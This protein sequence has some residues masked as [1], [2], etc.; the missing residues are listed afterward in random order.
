MLQTVIH[1]DASCMQLPGIQHTA[2]EDGKWY[3]ALPVEADIWHRMGICR[4]GRHIRSRSTVEQW[5][6]CWIACTIYTSICI[7]LE[8]PSSQPSFSHTPVTEAKKKLA[9]ANRSLVSCAYSKST[10]SI[11]TPRPWNPG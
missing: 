5:C 9:I 7:T 4:V 6:E 1:S 2:N 3:N 8:Q 11:V 10:A